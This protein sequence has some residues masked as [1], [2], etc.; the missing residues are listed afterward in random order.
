[1]A[2]DKNNTAHLILLRDEQANDPIGMGYAAIDGQTKKTLDLFNVPA[3][4]VGGETVNEMLTP[5][6]LLES[7]VPD[8][9]TVDNKF[10]DGAR[11]WLQLL[12]EGTSDLSDDLSNNRDKVL[13]L[14]NENPQTDTYNAI[15]ALQRAISRAEVL[16]GVNTN[17]TKADWFAARD[18]VGV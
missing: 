5:S 2:F 14:F 15:A 10:S 7:I 1:M 3:N 4:N 11:T 6:L 17:I 8:D 9:L 13:E 18:Y 16:F 12:F